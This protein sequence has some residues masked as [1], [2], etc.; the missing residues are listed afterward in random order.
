[1]L[2]YVMTQERKPTGPPYTENNQADF[3]IPKTPITSGSFPC[4]ILDP[5]ARQI[6]KRIVL[7]SEDKPKSSWKHQ[8]PEAFELMKRTLKQITDA[9]EVL[10]D[11]CSL[12]G[13]KPQT[14]ICILREK[15][16]FILEQAVM[17]LGVVQ[18]MRENRIDSLDLIVNQ[19]PESLD[20]TDPQ[21]PLLAL[22][23]ALNQA[24]KIS[25]HT[26]RKDISAYPPLESVF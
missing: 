15:E 9:D 5:K 25:G 17:I 10:A 4:Y 21:L 2:Y 23:M 14:M 16:E 8:N 7:S 24:A 11:L 3:V 22:R 6:A 19:R 26:L 13:E 18:E 1:M 12:S 20:L